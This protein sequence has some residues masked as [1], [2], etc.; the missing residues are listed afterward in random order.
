MKSGLDKSSQNQELGLRSLSSTLE[1]LQNVLKK[2]Y[3][4][5]NENEELSDIK[6]HMKIYDLK[7]VNNNNFECV[8]SRNIIVQTTI[9]IHDIGRDIYVSG[10]IKNG[11]NRI[12][13]KFRLRYN[14]N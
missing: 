1:G 10:A 11:G 4:P 8:K 9:C 5:D 12:F 7:T 14:F 3:I 13:E 2:T 6:F